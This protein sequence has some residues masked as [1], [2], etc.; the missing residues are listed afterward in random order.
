MSV[1]ILF[2]IFP[3]I[4]I[5]VLIV[6]K[7]N[8]TMHQFPHPHLD[9]NQVKGKRGIFP[10]QKESFETPRGLTFPFYL[11]SQQKCKQQGTLYFPLGLLPI[12]HASCQGQD[13]SQP[14]VSLKETHTI[15][16]KPSVFTVADCLV[17]KCTVNI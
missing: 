11:S 9:Y 13:V 10:S 5:H 17:S 7:K 4:V 1:F 16:C 15:K 8:K 3:L 2:Y 6:S 14:C 12:E